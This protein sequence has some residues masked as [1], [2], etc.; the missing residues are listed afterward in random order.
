MP[1]ETFILYGLFFLSLAYSLWQSVQINHLRDALAA[2]RSLQ[3][4]HPSLPE[5]PTRAELQGHIDA[6]KAVDVTIGE[7]DSAQ[8]RMMLALHRAQAAR[9]KALL[10]QLDAVDPE[11]IRKMYERS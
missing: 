7:T 11:R 8:E 3:R 6:C 1:N 4:L 10:E 9:A 5:T 2:L